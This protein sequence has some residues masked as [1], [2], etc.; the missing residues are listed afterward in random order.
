MDGGPRDRRQN[1]EAKYSEACGPF[2]PLESATTTHR[3][4]SI[5]CVNQP[6]V[7]RRHMIPRDA[8]SGGTIL[9]GRGP[10]KNESPH[11]DSD[12]ESPHMDSD[13]PD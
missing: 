13:S 7:F 1:E 9:Q 8:L 4:V 3:N 2:R 6:A 5:R 12:N 10:V 11:M